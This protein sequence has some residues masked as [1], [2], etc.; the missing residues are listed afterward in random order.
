[1]KSLKQT[2]EENISSVLLCEGLRIKIDDTPELGIGSFENAEELFVIEF[3]KPSFFKNVYFNV[4]AVKNHSMDIRGGK[5]FYEIDRMTSIFNKWACTN[6]S[7]VYDEYNDICYCED[8]SRIYIFISGDDTKKLND[9]SRCLS[10]LNSM[11][12]T[13]ISIE[14]FLGQFNIS[15]GD[16]FL[17]DD[18][19]ELYKF[20]I[21]KEGN[22]S[23]E[24][25]KY[26]FVKVL[27]ILK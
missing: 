23:I 24:T 5:I 7:A 17:V 14:R 12:E 19:T 13:E 6:M 11:K 9:L 15:N 10:R 3:D 22:E 27:K 18:I 8:E 1:M 21:N 2:L 25:E 20:D 16:E 26:L 4:Y